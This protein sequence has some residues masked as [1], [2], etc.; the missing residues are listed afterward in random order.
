MSVNDDNF[1]VLKESNFAQWLSS[2]YYSKNQAKIWSIMQRE[3]GDRITKDSVNILSDKDFQE[4]ADSGIPLVVRNE[5]KRWSGW[6]GK[7][8][9]IKTIIPFTLI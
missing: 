9:F 1:S 4:L 6:M 3:L 5:L 8:F 2:F 7:L